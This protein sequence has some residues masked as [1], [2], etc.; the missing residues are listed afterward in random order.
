MIQVFKKRYPNLKLSAQNGG[1]VLIEMD[2]DGA[3]EIKKSAE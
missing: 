1:E 3:R 2:L